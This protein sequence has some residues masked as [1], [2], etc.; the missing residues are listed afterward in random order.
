MS[1]RIEAALEFAELGARIVPARG[2]NPGV[3][4]G[5]G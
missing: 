3:L 1:G 4:L 5:R 2:K